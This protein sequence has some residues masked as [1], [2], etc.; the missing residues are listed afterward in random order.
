MKT[1][2][3]YTHVVAACSLPEDTVYKLAAALLANKANMSALYKDMA[4][5]SP[6]VMALDIGVPFHAG[7]A[8]WFKEQ[9]VAVK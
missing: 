4:S 5:L 2:G 7:A 3:Y 1:I 9:G 8:K 6:Q